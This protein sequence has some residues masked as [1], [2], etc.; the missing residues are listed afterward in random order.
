MEALAQELRREIDIICGK[1]HY[2]KI[3]NVIEEARKLA[4]KIQEFCTGFLRGNIYGMEEEEY[5]S[6]QNYVLHVIEDYLDAM[7]YSDDIWMLD[8]LDFGLRELI[9]IYIDEDTEEKDHE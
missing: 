4:E 5:Q 9:N 2:E 3:D 6:L 7:T 8:T 1:Y